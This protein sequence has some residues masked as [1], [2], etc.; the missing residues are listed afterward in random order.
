MKVVINRCYG[1]FNLS[2]EAYKLIAKRKGWIVA[3]ND[4]YIDYWIP[5]LGKD[6]KYYCHDLERTDPD[7]VAVVEELGEKADGYGAEL[8]IVNIPDN[9]EWHIQEYDGMEKVCENYRTW[10]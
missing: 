6:K 10:L 1:G 4:F 8:K 9:I 5:E 3:T 7:L 2:F